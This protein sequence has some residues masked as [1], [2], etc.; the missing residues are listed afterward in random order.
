VVLKRYKNKLL[1]KKQILSEVN[2]VREIMGLN[3]LEQTKEKVKVG[4]KK[5]EF[6][7]L[8]TIIF[9]STY[10]A[11]DDKTTQSMFNLFLDKLLEAIDNNPD[12]SSAYRSGT[13]ELKTAKV[14]AGA[15]NFYTG[16]A[17]AADFMNDR[18]TPM[19]ELITI[20]G[21]ETVSGKDL[22]TYDLPYYDENEVVVKWD[23][24]SKPYRGNTDLAFRRADNFINYIAEKLPIMNI[25]VFPQL[26]RIPDGSIIDT[27]GVIDKERDVSVYPN[28]GQVIIAD[29][30]FGYREVVEVFEERCT[31]D[32]T[33]E[34]SAGG[35]GGGHK[36]DEAIF[37][38]AINGSMLGV[39]NLNNS[40]IDV[41]GASV[42]RPNIKNPKKTINVDTYLPGLPT[43]TRY[44]NERKTDGKGGGVRTAVFSIDPKNPD[45]KWGR[46]N[47]ITIQSLV[48]QDGTFGSV[49]LGS[50]GIHADVPNVKITNADGIA[51]PGDRW[52]FK[53]NVNMNRGSMK[54][55]TLLIVD[56][57]GVP[58]KLSEYNPKGKNYNPDAGSGEYVIPS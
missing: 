17:T 27:G 40:G 7:E 57:C 49:K 21:E 50:K 20:S 46:I 31:A 22:L 10:R 8:D 54:V 39:A 30:L 3:L 28:P 13:L 33:I 37:R 25:S 11:N 47:K 6:M 29:L 26:S 9:D 2:R 5:G 58:W 19:P 36:C 44:P 56:K 53:P 24:H 23:K 41:K 43:S 15:S 55:T 4:E 35:E 42:P 32:L 38:V 1:M 18:I 12:A 16:A 52:G 14:T 45:F 48:N 51:T 34:I